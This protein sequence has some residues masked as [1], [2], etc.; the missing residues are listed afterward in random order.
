MHVKL[1]HNLVSSLLIWKLLLH[2]AVVENF[3]F[4][5]L[6]YLHTKSQDIWILKNIKLIINLRTSE[7]VFQCSLN[8][9]FLNQAFPQN[10]LVFFRLSISRKL[11]K[12][13]LVF[14]CMIISL[15]SRQVR[16]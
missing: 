3:K 8:Q 15:S 7:S 10:H 1:I 2:L 16:N 14:L 11:R 5:F 9:L 6:D 13:W 4:Y 12:Y